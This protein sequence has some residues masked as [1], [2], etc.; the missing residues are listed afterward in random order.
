MEFEFY[1]LQTTLPGPK[2]WISNRIR[3]VYLNEVTFLNQRPTDKHMHIQERTFIVSMSECRPNS[4]FSYILTNEI[5]FCTTQ[6]LYR[7][8]TSLSHETSK[9]VLFSVFFESFMIHFSAIALNWS[10]A[11][12]V[13]SNSCFFWKRTTFALERELFKRPCHEIIWMNHLI[14]CLPYQLVQKIQINPTN[15]KTLII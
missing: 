7:S 5:S 4:W 2:F 8:S 11:S 12:T 13:Y 1:L 15:V 10:S 14:C 3:G 9:D 6:H